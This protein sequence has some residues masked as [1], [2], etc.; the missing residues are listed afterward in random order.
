MGDEFYCEGVMITHKKT[1]LIFIEFL[2][3]VSEPV[4]SDINWIY[5][6]VTC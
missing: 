3:V 1:H 2:S 6:S 5:V 4:S